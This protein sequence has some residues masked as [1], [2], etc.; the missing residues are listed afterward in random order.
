MPDDEQQIL[1]L[2]CDQEAAHARGD[3]AGVVRPLADDVVSYDLPPPLAYR[4]ADARDTGGLDQW[5]ATWEDGVTVELAEPTV[6]IDGDLAVVFGL[7]RMRGIKKD[8]GP[9]DIWNRRTVALR[10]RD[11]AWAI[12]HDHSSYP[13]LMDGSDKAALDLK[14]AKEG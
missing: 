12:V 9:T 2:L 5:F 8:S 3:A 7:S 11:R 10:R 1:A 14:P 4:G 6:L 13:M